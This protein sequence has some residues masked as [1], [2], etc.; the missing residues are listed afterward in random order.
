MNATTFTREAPTKVVTAKLGS[1]TLEFTRLSQLSR[2]PKWHSAAQ[3]VLNEL[4]A[5]QARTAIPGLL[6]SFLDA[7][8][9][10]FGEKLR[11]SE[12]VGGETYT[13]GALVD[14][15]YE[16][17]SKYHLLLEGRNPQPRRMYES[18]VGPAILKLLFRPMT[19]G[20]DDIL[21]AGHIDL[22]PDHEYFAAT[23]DHLQC[24][25]GG[26]FALASK[27]FN[28]PQDLV[29][30][31]KLTKGCVWA[32]KS[33]ASGVMPEIMTAIPCLSKKTGE[34]AWNDDIWYAHVLGLG[35]LNDLGEKER[36]DAKAKISALGLA[37][38]FASAGDP[39]YLL[40]YV[41][42]VLSCCTHFVFCTN[43][44]M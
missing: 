22:F 25:S 27:V 26:M 30:G 18:F 16:Y 31:E 38:G 9:F 14:S 39:S 4:E 43:A 36:G 7:T 17:L 34:C 33:T 23:L 1:L 37:P 5:Y 2:N 41:F 20:E 15:T 32:Y 10:A 44:S 6:P 13:L 8:G 3:N 42:S 19:M 35:S 40:R 24:F 11:K 12:E 28:R 29:I 21:I